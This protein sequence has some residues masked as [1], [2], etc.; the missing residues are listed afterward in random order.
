MKWINITESSQIK[1]LIE[2]SNDKAVIIFKHSP[3]CHIS[4]FAL[5]NFEASFANPTETDCYLVDVVNDRLHSMELKEIL[6]VQHESPQLIIVSKGKAVYNTSHESI[7]G[8]TTEKL[9]LRL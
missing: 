9:L 1:E 4:K 5:R 3:R 8:V 2:K 7:D 6:A